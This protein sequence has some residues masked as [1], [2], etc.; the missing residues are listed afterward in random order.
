MD[1]RMTLYQH[2]VLSGG[3]TMYPGMP[4]RLDKDI[5]VLYLS[6]VLKVGCIC[7]HKASPWL[8]A[9]LDECCIGL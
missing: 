2:I 1:N 8:T 5:K 9:S 4:S 3:S 7:L 6:K